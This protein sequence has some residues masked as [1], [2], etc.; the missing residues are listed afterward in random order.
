MP[1][2]SGAPNARLV[3]DLRRYQAELE[4][5]NKALRFSQ[6]A[7][8]GAYERFVT[9]FSS[10]PLALMVCD[11]DGQILEFNARALAL[12][13]PQESDPPLNFLLPLVVQEHRPLVM[14]GFER[15]AREGTCELDELRFHG[16][17]QGCFTGDLHIARIDNTQDELVSFICA[18]IDQSQLL[19]QR[20]ALHDSAQTLRERN[21]ELSQS[22]N[23]LGAI[24]DGSFDAIICVDAQ[25]TVVVFNP[26]A[27][28]LFACPPEVALGQSLERFLPAAA[29]ALRQLKAAGRTVL[30]EMACCTQDGRNVMLEVSV[31]LAQQDEAQWATLFIHDLTEQHRM[32]AQRQALELQLRESQKMQAIGTMAGGI[33]HD[34][35][36]IIS[37]ILGNVDLAHAELSPEHP[38][39]VSLREI[40]KAARRARDL[41]RQI[42][43][44]SRNQP[45]Q[46]VPVQLADVAQDSLRLLRV[47][48]PPWVEL[49]TSIAPNLPWVAADATQ[50][51]QVLLNLCTNAIHALGNQPGVLCLSLTQVDA[52]PATLVPTDPEVQDPQP[53]RWVCLSVQ[54]NGAG[55]AP[56]VMDRIF[57][58]FFTTKPVGQGTGLGLSVVHGIVRAHQGRI[59]VLSEPG[60]GSTFNLYF[61]ARSA[62]PM[63]TRAGVEPPA[64]RGSGQRVM[65][66]DDDEA[67]VFL[68]QRALKRQGFVVHTYTDPHAALQVLRDPNWACDLLVT[69]FNMPG[70]SGVELLRS[71][72]TLRPELPTVLASG[73]VTPD[74]EREARSAGARALFH[75]P[76]DVD[77]LCRTILGLLQDHGR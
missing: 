1:G 52:L 17:L 37:A 41:V 6:T 23:R 20:Q 77:A 10:V 39:G 58:P 59:Q 73:Y 44:F 45:P 31:S 12:L 67:L 27:A 56:E 35:N 13:R 11:E 70:F 28:Q 16:G 18:V 69:D 66:V 14:Q 71:V 25:Q 74:I 47:N 42:L 19:A 64:A 75:K 49:R 46:R 76:N 72:Q 4:I 50:M 43:T 33:A 29:K 5:Q 34:F 55:I 22:R 9:L 7:A 63:P 24:I 51:E 40:G 26:S 21:A 15:A 38:A 54:D 3:A 36:N 68:V 60:K 57:E 61:P 8:E 62:P 32:Q 30:G 53:G 65:Y 2:L 48:L